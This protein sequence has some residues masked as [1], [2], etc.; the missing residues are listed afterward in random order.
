MK[1]VKGMVRSRVPGQRRR[2]ARTGQVAAAGLLGVTMLTGTGLIG[3]TA[4]A[5]VVANGRQKSA[6]SSAQTAALKEA[7]SA[8]QGPSKF[9]APGPKLNAAKVKALKGDS[10]M[11]LGV[12]EN[13]F[14]TE[15]LTGVRNAAK[16]AGLKVIYDNDLTSTAQVQDIDTAI[17][18]HAKAIILECILPSA[19]SSAI[20]K[21]K[22]AGVTVIAAC[23]GD[24]GLPSATDKKIG[25]YGYVTYSYTESGRLIA[26]YDVLKT[27]GHVNAMIQWFHGL[28]ASDDT[29][30]GFKS[31]LKQYCPKTCTS[32]ATDI[33]L[34]SNGEDS[35]LVS[36]AT[37]AVANPSIN[38]FFPVYDFMVSDDEPIIT[39]SHANSR[40][41]IGTQNA[42]LAPMQQL[43][44]GDTAVKVEVGN[45]T[46][47]DGWGCVDQALRG[48]T[49]MAPVADEH[50]PLRVFDPSN[51][52][53]VH[54]K[55]PEGTWYG[56]VN[57]AADYKQLWGV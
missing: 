2:L 39:S 29:V 6:L 5:S 46:T 51:I 22:A 41:I 40:I 50:L 16:A 31:V 19:V 56:P 33:P 26:D 53:S 11:F 55:Q 8:A 15:L 49:G 17:S 24:P 18:E 30:A 54:L 47:W 45:P 14:N 25:V 3:S 7:L 35:T 10:I 28:A 27:G 44:S 20:G 9:V 12:G 36:S 38:V 34:T 52:K 21:A 13:Q 1:T 37:A 32:S 4:S 48:M 42:D 57:Y 23:D 43:A